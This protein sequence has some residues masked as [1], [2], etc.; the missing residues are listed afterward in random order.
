MIILICL[1]S[2]VGK[3][4]PPISPSTIHVFRNADNLQNYFCLSMFM[5]PLYFSACDC[6]THSITKSQQLVQLIALGIMMD[7]DRK[8]CSVITSV[9]QVA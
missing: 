9:D 7:N 6:V 3:F 2:C 1:H 5:Q 8:D 4:D